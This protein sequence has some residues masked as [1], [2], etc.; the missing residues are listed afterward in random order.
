M[1]I[2]IPTDSD[3]RTWMIGVVNEKI[4]HRVKLAHIAR[5]M[6]VDYNKLWR[7]VNNENVTGEFYIKWFK[8]YIKGEQ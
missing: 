2:E 7:F 8:W 4:T 3:I 6:D 1:T 5:E